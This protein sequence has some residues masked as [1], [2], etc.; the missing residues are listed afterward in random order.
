MEVTIDGIR[1]YSPNLVH[2]RIELHEELGMKKPTTLFWVVAGKEKRIRAKHFPVYPKNTRFRVTQGTAYGSLS[3]RDGS[4]RDLTEFT[5]SDLSENKVWYKH[6]SMAT[7]AC[8]D[9]FTFDVIF[10]DASQTRNSSF[11][12]VIRQ[13]RKDLDVN[14]TVK[15]YHF[16]N[17]TRFLISNQTFKLPPHSVQS[18]RIQ[19]RNTPFPWCV[20]PS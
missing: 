18:C 5:R 8:S 19:S 3:Y 14:I 16:F 9:S 12:I 4:E 13:G 6:D 20:E 2:L 1:S 7:F 15:S 11:L 10:E 17:T